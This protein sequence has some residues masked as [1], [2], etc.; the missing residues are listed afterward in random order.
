M[1]Y[2]A[3]LKGDYDIVEGFISALIAREGY[4]P[5]KITAI[6]DGE[7]NKEQLYLKKSIADLVVEDQKGDKYIVEI[8]REYTSN[9]IHKA[10]FNTSRLIVDSIG[11]SEDY[12]TIKKVFHI[13]LIYFSWGN[14]TKPLYHGKTIIRELD[15]KHPIDLHVMDLGGKIQYASNIF[16]EYILISVPLFDDL[17]REELDEWLYLLKHSEVKEDFKS[18]YMKKVAERLNFLKMDEYEKSDY[19]RYKQETLRQ[20]DTISA[21]EEKGE[22]RGIQ[23]G[24]QEGIQ[25]GIQ[26]GMQQGKQAEKIEIAR[27]MLLEL[28]LGLDIVQKATGLSKEELEKLV[29]EAK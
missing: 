17:V 10:C 6:L 27:N 12:T 15:T 13:S 1:L 2:D 3:N 22:A 26:E 16:P 23:Q 8:E 11:S 28:K 20:R 29:K 19:Y 5:V 9:F 7:S 25:K 4:S 14:M 24:M 18:P 21:A